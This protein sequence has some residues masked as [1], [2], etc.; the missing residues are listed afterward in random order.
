FNDE[1]HVPAQLAPHCR[2][3][4]RRKICVD[5]HTRRSR[6][7]LGNRP[8]P[9]CE[10]AHVRQL[11]ATFLCPLLSRV[12]AARPC[13]GAAAPPRARR[14][15]GRGSCVCACSTCCRRHTRRRAG[16][17]SSNRSTRRPCPAA[18]PDSPCPRK[19]PPTAWRRTGRP[20]PP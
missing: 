1:K 2:D 14:D 16:T 7:L 13:P 8:Q 19:L 18:R 20:T 10:R 17:R 5:I 4:A 6:E 11:I 12:S 9:G 3:G 15:D